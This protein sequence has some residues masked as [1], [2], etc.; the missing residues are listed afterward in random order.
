MFLK[1]GSSSSRTSSSLF[2]PA[3]RSRELRACTGEEV[4]DTEEAEDLDECPRDHTDAVGEADGVV[5]DA[6]LCGKAAILQ[7]M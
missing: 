3:N 6:G 4:N 7:W 2:C 1:D 5:E